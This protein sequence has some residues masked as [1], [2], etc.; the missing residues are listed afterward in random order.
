MYRV[1][2][3]LHTR[4][5]CGLRL[6][7]GG[8]RDGRRR[9]PGTSPSAAGPAT[10]TTTHRTPSTVVWETVYVIT[11]DKHSLLLLVN[12]QIKC[13]IKSVLRFDD[14][15]LTC[16]SLS[17]RMLGLQVTLVCNVLR[18]SSDRCIYKPGRFCSSNQPV[19]LNESMKPRVSYNYI[20]FWLEVDK[21]R[22]TK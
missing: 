8:L 5:G 1:T 14:A 17:A 15:P 18:K 22:R 21:I 16:N 20:I 9:R 12:T 10:G 11:V 2:K 7:G 13:L 6:R 4:S 3:A 19:K